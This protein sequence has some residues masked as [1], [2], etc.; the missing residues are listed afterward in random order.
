MIYPNMINDSND[1]SISKHS[2]E[3][4]EEESSVSPTD[5]NFNQSPVS[6]FDDEEQEEIILQ[7]DKSAFRSK[8]GS[9]NNG[10]MRRRMMNN[11]SGLSHDF[12]NIDFKKSILHL[13]WHPTENSVAI[14]ATN[15]LFIF[16][17][18]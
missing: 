15:N 4:E 16:S 3:E 11:E 10:G 17:T 6:N 7:A 2:E 9:N 1:K 5:G 18:L 8:K 12:D 13:S 14:A